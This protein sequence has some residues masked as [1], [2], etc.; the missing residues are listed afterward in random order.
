M[1]VLKL[2]WEFFKIGA[3]TFGGGYAMI[4]MVKTALV[5]KRKWLNE[6]EF[7]ECITLAQSLPGV[8]AINMALYTGFKISGKS[9]S[10]GAM[11][12]AALPSMIIIVLVA[13]FI[14]NING[15]KTVKDIFAGI[16]PC[17][18]ALILVPGLTMLKKA[19][20]DRRTF[21][22]P[23]LACL[24]VCLLGISPMYFIIA[25]IIG[26]IIW[27]KIVIRKS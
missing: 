24:A 20:L 6:D 9:G 5:D 1:L 17:V 10:F 22:I 11:A 19:K 7:W 4:S 26:G 16:R 13:S 15:L 27:A 23:V 3:F 2:F 14:Q 18:I 21:W 25:A 12:G 8:F